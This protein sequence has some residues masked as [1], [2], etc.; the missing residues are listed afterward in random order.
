MADISG[1]PIKGLFLAGNNLNSCPDFRSQK[2]L[3]LAHLTPKLKNFNAMRHFVPK[4]IHILVVSGLRQH[5]HLIFVFQN[6]QHNRYLLV[7]LIYLSMLQKFST[8]YTNPT[9]VK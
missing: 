5:Y 7:L 8:Y 6:I 1:L 9:L 2:N 4:K 3:P